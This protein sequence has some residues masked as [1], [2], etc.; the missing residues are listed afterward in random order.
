MKR[1]VDDDAGYAAWLAAH[2]RGHVLNLFPH[3]SSSYLV[4]HRSSCRTVNRH[5]AAGRR[6]TDQGGKA[7]SDDPAELAAWARRETGKSIHTCSA[8]RP[9]A[10]T[11]PEPGADD[12]EQHAGR[13]DLVEREPVWRGSGPMRQPTVIG[14]SPRELPSAAKV[15]AAHEEYLRAEGRDVVYRVARDIIERAYR[16]EGQFTIGEGVAVLLLSWNAA[17]YRPRPA[18]L[19]TLADDLDRLVTGNGAQLD[20]YRTRSVTSF[21][22][23]VDAPT[24]EGLYRAFVERLWPVGAAKALHVLAPGFFP[25][26][27]DAIARRFRLQLSP[28]E[29]SVRSYLALIAIGKQFAM[30]SD[31]PMPLKALDEWAYVRFT[32]PGRRGTR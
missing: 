25:L 4:L 11:A 19:R 14:G 18:L 12:P 2:P 22:P 20:T 8:C 29:A 32:L 13:L 9:A 10:P 28:R 27:D 31:L 16:G 5:L 6:W 21:N 24:I 30:T 3:V 17:F 1:F 23:G 15:V 26:W 7:C